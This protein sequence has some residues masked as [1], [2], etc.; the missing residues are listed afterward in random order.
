MLKIM[1][2]VECGMG[3]AEVILTVWALTLG[4]LRAFKDLK[5]FKDLRGGCGMG[6]DGV[7][8][9]LGEAFFDCLCFF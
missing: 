3:C 7:F 6:C 5:D 4:T 2:N 9:G 8:G 1:L